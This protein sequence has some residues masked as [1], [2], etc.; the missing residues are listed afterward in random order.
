MF[1]K[2]LK[3]ALKRK[4]SGIGIFMQA[5]NASGMFLFPSSVEIHALEGIESS[6]PL[7]QRENRLICH[8]M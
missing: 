5:L 3:L 8:K 7:S 6:L 4:L 1:S 2:Y